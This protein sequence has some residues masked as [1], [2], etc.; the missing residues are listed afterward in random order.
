MT[1]DFFSCLKNP[2][3]FYIVRHGE[4]DG[5][6][7]KILQGRFE[8]PLSEMGRLQSA[9]RG[10]EL[11]SAIAGAAPGKTQLFSSPLGRA[12]ETALIIAEESGLPGPT[13]IDGLMEM[14]L[15]IWTGKTWDEVKNDD[16]SL[17]AAFMARSWDAIPEAES[18][19]ALYERALR[20]WAA[21]RDAAMEKGAEKIVVVTHGGLIQWLLKTTFR[22]RTWFPL[23]PISNCGLSKLCVVPRPDE[24]SAWLNW[25]EIDSRLPH[26]GSEPR[27]FP[28]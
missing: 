25:E 3:D 13:V 9:A 24:L 14:D 2:L 12:R 1:P 8:Y 17:W 10:R 20:L 4:S 18:S 26:L 6:A 27:G 7:A 21:L 16:P 23:F 5:N 11:K 28:S 22:C 15:G 19:S